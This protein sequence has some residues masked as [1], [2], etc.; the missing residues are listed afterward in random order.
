LYGNGNAVPTR[1]MLEGQL[2]NKRSDNVKPPSTKQL[3]TFRIKRISNRFGVESLTFIFNNDNNFY[4]LVFDK[5][6]HYP[7]TLEPVSVDD[8][9]AHKLR[10]RQD[11]VMTPCSGE[12]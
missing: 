8:G 9:I 2:I 6:P 11:N 10:R 5:H 4:V 1:N 3:P 12:P 7:I